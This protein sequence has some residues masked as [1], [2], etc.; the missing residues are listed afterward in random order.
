[1]LK[2]DVCQTV[3]GEQGG[4][5]KGWGGELMGLQQIVKEELCDHENKS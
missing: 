2:G 3:K 1:M 4:G 5:A